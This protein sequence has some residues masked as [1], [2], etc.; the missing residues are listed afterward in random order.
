MPS[1]CGTPCNALMPSQQVWRNSPRLAG[2]FLQQRLPSP[3]LRSG[4]RGKLGPPLFAARVIVFGEPARSEG[5]RAPSD[6]SNECATAARPRNNK[7]WARG[8]GGGHQAVTG[9]IQLPPAL[10]PVPAVIRLGAGAGSQARA[11]RPQL[12]RDEQWRGAAGGR[13]G[14]R[15]GIG[16]AG[17]RHPGEGPCAAVAGNVRDSG[18]HR[19][20]ICP[21]LPW[22]PV[23]LVAGRPGERRE[24]A[25]R[26]REG[27]LLCFPDAQATTKAVRICLQWMGTTWG[28]GKLG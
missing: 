3:P 5:E 4:R 16:A 14:A 7:A 8:R 26:A 11:P 6:R 9:E 18:T 10:S 12:G 23:L 21:L 1:A 27:A 2:G 19:G 17:P 28:A 24:G 15:G 13:D 25:P 20:R 22:C